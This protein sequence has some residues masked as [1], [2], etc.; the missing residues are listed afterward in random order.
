MASFPGNL[1][2][3]SVQRP[4]LTAEQNVVGSEEVTADKNPKNVTCHCALEM[5][6]GELKIRVIS[7]FRKDALF[8]RNWRK[9]EN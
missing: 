6:N 5:K 2:V 7:C 3:A 8:I 1:C 4:Q 9:R